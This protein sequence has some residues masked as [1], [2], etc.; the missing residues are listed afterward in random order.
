M[1]TTPPLPTA[2]PLTLQDFKAP[3]PFKAPSFHLKGFWRLYISLGG[4]PLFRFV[5]VYSVASFGLLHC[6]EASLFLKFNPLLLRDCLFFQ[7][8]CQA[9]CI[10]W[11]FPFLEK[12]GL[13]EFVISGFNLATPH[14]PS[15]RSFLFTVLSSLYFSD[16]VKKMRVLFL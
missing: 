9:L 6:V 13:F 1:N 16:L 2:P 12:A 15:K 11:C 7:S 4:T 14:R 5:L 8:A 3:R 10:I